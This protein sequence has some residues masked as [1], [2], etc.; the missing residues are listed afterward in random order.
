MLGNFLFLLYDHLCLIYYY[1]FIQLQTSTDLV[2]PV[3]KYPEN[4]GF[5]S[6]LI[7]IV[8]IV[9]YLGISFHFSWHC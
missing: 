3:G 8:Y 6:Y 9:Y 7:N 1:F 5:F 2:Q 4:S